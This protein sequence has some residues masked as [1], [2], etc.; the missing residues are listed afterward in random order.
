MNDV[1]S[2]KHSDYLVFQRVGDE[3]IMDREK[4]DWEKLEQYAI[5]CLNL[6]Q[7]MQAS[8]DMRLEENFVVSET[9][10]NL[11]RNLDALDDCDDSEDK[12]EVYINSSILSQKDNDSFEYDRERVSNHLLQYLIEPILLFE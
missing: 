8:T 4:T 6:S 2:I 3:F 7:F 11:K 1:L 5:Q 10:K 12:L 9:L